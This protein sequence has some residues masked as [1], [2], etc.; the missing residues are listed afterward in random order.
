MAPTDR[1]LDAESQNVTSTSLD[2]I[3]GT[4]ANEKRRFTLYYLR[5]RPTT[6]VDELADVLAT[7]ALVDTPTLSLSGYRDEMLIRLDHVHLQKLEAMSLVTYDRET[8]RVTLAALPPVV[9]SVL[10]H[11]MPM[12]RVDLA[13]AFDVEIG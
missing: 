12:E 13:D 3:F 6:T 7:K 9:E 1:T 11:A 10:D 8:G 4:L 2:E 5:E